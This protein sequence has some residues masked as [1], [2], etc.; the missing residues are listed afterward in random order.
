MAWSMSAN[1]ARENLTM[2]D[3]YPPYNSGTTRDAIDLRETR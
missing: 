2:P 1:D 3:A